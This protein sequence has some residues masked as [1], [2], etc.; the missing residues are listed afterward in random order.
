MGSYYALTTLLAALNPARP[1][2][3]LPALAPRQ[4]EAGGD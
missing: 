3:Y 1:R 4:I 2:T